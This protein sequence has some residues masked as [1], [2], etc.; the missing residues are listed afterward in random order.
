M[1]TKQKAFHDW[2]ELCPVDFQHVYSIKTDEKGCTSEL[3]VFENIPIF[4]IVKEK[5]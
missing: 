3:Y 1:T 2:M 4:E 5:K